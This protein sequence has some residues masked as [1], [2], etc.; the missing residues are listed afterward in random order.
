MDQPERDEFR[1]LTT[2]EEALLAEVAS[3][4]AGSESV[5][6]ICESLS[7]T[8]NSLAMKFLREGMR[9]VPIFVVCSYR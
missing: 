2:L 1:E 5:A 9:T 4:G 8:Y 3:C 7:R 6:Q